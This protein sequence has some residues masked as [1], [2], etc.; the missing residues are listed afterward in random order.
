MFKK[1]DIHDLFLASINVT[2]PDNEMWDTNFGG[3]LRMGIAG[4]GYMTILRQEGDTYID[5]ENASRK[6]T[7][8]RDPKTVSHTIDYIVPLSKYYT[9]EGKKKKIFS[10]KEALVEAQK[11]YH[12]VHLEYLAQ[13]PEEQSVRKSL[14][15]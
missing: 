4:Y 8:A 15:L 3:I 5:L 9:Q 11:Y 7:T 1:Y 14:S 12:A 13:L 10:R 6:I 2:Y